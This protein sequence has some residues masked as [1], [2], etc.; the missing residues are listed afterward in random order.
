[1]PLR[2]LEHRIGTALKRRSRTQKTRSASSEEF[3]A[4][5]WPKT[6]RGIAMEGELRDGEPREDRHGAG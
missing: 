6:A 2:N 3:V 5:V 4:Q 1:M